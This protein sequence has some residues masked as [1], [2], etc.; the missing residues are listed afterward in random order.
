MATR[1]IRTYRNGELTRTEDVEITDEADRRDRFEQRLDKAVDD[2]TDGATWRGLTA[3]AKVET[4]RLALLVLIRYVRN[5]Y[6]ADA[7]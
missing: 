3:A 7:Q 4:I 5:R 6:E 2:L 1:T